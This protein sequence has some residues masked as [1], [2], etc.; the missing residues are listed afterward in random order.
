V[1]GTRFARKPIELNIPVMIAGMSWGTLS[2]NA[3]VALARGA[4]VVGF[5]QHNW[6][7][8]HADRRVRK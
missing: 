1:L 5:L 8:W 7:R 6:G 2:Y 4:A 3:N